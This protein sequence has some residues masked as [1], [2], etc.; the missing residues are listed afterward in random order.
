MGQK[1]LGNRHYV[2]FQITTLHILAY[3]QPACAIIENEYGI[4]PRSCLT[5]KEQVLFD[6]QQRLKLIRQSIEDSSQH[7]DIDGVSWTA[8]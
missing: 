8:N 1:K 3:G 5:D 2:E 7:Y 6:N 4:T